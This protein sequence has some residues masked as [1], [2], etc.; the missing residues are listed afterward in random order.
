V[1]RMGAAMRRPARKRAWRLASAMLLLAVLVVL[2]APSGSQPLF[3]SGAERR[4]APSR[5]GGQGRPMESPDFASPTGS[6]SPA[7]Q[8]AFGWS[9]ARPMSQ[10]QGLDAMVAKMLETAV[11]TDSEGAGSDQDSLWRTARRTPRG[12]IRPGCDDDQLAERM[13][14][15]GQSWSGQ[16]R[17]AAPAQFP[18]GVFTESSAAD[19]NRPGDPTSGPSGN[20]SNLSSPGPGPASGWCRPAPVPFA[21]SSPL[22]GRTF[23]IAI[24]FALMV[25]VVFWL[26]R[27]LR[28]PA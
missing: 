28:M 20:R 13:Q 2:P 16:A 10:T 6:V 26:S 15:G 19:V 8:T 7:L 3:S 14:A 27:G 1:V 18:A 5:L 17:S 11:S 23:W 9:V 25:A 4:I 12:G 24:A 22:A 21:Q